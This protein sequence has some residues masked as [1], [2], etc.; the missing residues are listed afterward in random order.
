LI[1]RIARKH[2]TW[3]SQRIQGE[4]VEFDHDPGALGESKE[5]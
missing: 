4:P 5:T 2:M 3:G 1:L